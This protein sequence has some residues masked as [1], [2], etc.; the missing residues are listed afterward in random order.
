MADRVRPIAQHPLG[1]LIASYV[2]LAELGYC[3][4]QLAIARREIVDD[5]DLMPARYQRIDYMRADEAGSACDEHALWRG[6]AV[7]GQITR[8]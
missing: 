2:H 4:D 6:G 8:R 5:R 3:V 1:R 7:D